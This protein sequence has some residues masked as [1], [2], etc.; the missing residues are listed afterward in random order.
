MM[1]PPC[2]TVGRVFIPKEH[3]R[4][5]TKILSLVS[6]DYNVL[7]DFSQCVVLCVACVFPLEKRTS[8]SGIHSPY[9]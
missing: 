9:L 1:Q 3:F 5:L 4:N 7:V 2:F 8:L 6:F